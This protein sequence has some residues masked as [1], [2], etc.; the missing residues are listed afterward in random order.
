[1]KSLPELETVHLV[2]QTSVGVLHPLV[3]KRVHLELIVAV[4]VL[5]NRSRARR[6]RQRVMTAVPRI[7]VRAVAREQ[8][9][10]MVG[11]PILDL[12]TFVVRVGPQVIRVVVVVGNRL[13]ITALD[14]TFTGVPVPQTHGGVTTGRSPPE[15]I[16]VERTGSAIGDVRLILA[17]NL[18]VLHVLL[19]DSI[20]ELLEV[21][22]VLSHLLVEPRRYVRLGQQDRGGGHCSGSNQNRDHASKDSFGHGILSDW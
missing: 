2:P 12:T 13:S 11:H 3:P 7:D 21:L 1:M 6:V 16:V 20:F 15:C 9:A 5:V 14:L 22:V 17:L 10:A 19:G 8:L 18:W 4:V